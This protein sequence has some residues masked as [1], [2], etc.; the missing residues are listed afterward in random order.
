M[1]EWHLVLSSTPTNVSVYTAEKHGT[2]RIKTWN[3]S[4]EVLGRK[5][6]FSFSIVSIYV[7]AIAEKKI[8]WTRKSLQVNIMSDGIIFRV[9][10]FMFIFLLFILDL[11]IRSFFYFST[12][13]HSWSLVLIRSYSW[14]LV[15]TRGQSWSP[16]IL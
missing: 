10:Y 11:F 1:I 3:R 14:S 7:F 9:L 6:A 13:G 8:I 16:H 5:R 15:V 2:A 12:R 4:G